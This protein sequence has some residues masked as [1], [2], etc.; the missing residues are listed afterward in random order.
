MFTLGIASS[1]AQPC[2]REGRAKAPLNLN[3]RRRIVAMEQADID[4]IR[5]WAALHPVIPG[6]EG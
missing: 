5:G 1:V 4:A 2:I 3:V 6:L